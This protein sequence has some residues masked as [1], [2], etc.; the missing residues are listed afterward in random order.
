M[1]PVRGLDVEVLGGG[2]QSVLGQVAAVIPVGNELTR[3]L[4]VQIP[5]PAGEWAIGT[6]VRVAMPST[7]ARRV[8]AINRDA[9]VFAAGT[10]YVLRVDDQ[11]VVS[12]VPVRLG[13]GQGTVIEVIG[14]LAI[15]D[16]LVVRGGD[17]LRPGAEVQV[18]RTRPTHIEP[19]RYSNQHPKHKVLQEEPETAEGV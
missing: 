3:T 11:N 13:E 8:L 2:D 10:S 17:R 5:L 15:D 14:D 18:V 1:W 4:E 12:R 9:V 16:K 6:A 7:Q 19:V